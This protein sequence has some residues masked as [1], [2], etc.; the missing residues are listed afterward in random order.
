MLFITAETSCKTCR[1]VIFVQRLDGDIFCNGCG[2]LTPLA[3][4]FGKTLVEAALALGRGLADGGSTSTAV[5]GLQLLVRRAAPA[6]PSC[7][8]PPRAIS[9]FCASC[10]LPNLPRR[11][12]GATVIGEAPPPQP[13]R[14]KTGSTGID[15]FQCRQCGSPISLE[16]M[17]STT[18][19]PFCKTANHI[20]RGFYY[21]GH[22]P[23]A[24]KIALEPEQQLAEQ[25][26]AI[27]K[28]L[29]AAVPL[30]RVSWQ[31]FPQPRGEAILTTY[32][33]IFRIDS[34]LAL[35]WA[36]TGIK[37][38]A[39]PGPTLE[40]RWFI[41]GPN[42][43]AWCEGKQLKRINVSTG[44]ELPLMPFPEAWS[45]VF[46]N[47]SILLGN[48]TPIYAKGGVVWRW[49]NNE[50]VRA[51]ELKHLAKV[52]SMTA[53]GDEISTAVTDGKVELV[54]YAADLTPLGRIEAPALPGSAK[55]AY[56]FDG[57]SCAMMV[58][59]G[60]SLAPPGGAM[61][62]LFRL[63]KSKARLIAF[64]REEGF[65]LLSP[66]GGIERYDIAGK[67]TLVALATA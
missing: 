42:V 35:V 11:L 34:S 53:S 39:F 54:R 17:P 43:I 3:P 46:R 4:G 55:W 38:Q 36:R 29:L 66:G 51:P 32:D 25:P 33:A 13:P 24:R 27:P 12:G 44:E 57:E 6:C 1:G 65:T 18:Q 61:K 5:A 23:T 22:M 26:R 28:E 59:K 63:S 52:F 56:A 16:G 19:C 60:V 30:D 62:E 67:L 40:D 64:G 41:A 21:R 20:P 49:Q 50:F 7:S 14:A 8:A 2:E 31:T 10:G 47:P 45:H 15:S 9:E 48:D 37:P 58:G